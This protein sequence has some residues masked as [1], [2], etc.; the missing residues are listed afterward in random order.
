MYIRVLGAK[1]PKVYFLFATIFWVSGFTSSNA[2]LYFFLGAWGLAGTFIAPLIW[3]R[4]V[5][6]FIRS[7][8]GRP[9]AWW[10]LILLL[11]S[12]AIALVVTLF[13][14]CLLIWQ[15]VIEPFVDRHSAKIEEEYK[16][17]KALS[18]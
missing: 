15:L 12:F 14:P 10:S 6:N 4:L 17:I 16:V 11:F 13:L 2:L 9:V 3:K 5:L 7:Q 1:A 8:D 18:R